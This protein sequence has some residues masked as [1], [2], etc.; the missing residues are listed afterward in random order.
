MEGSL[1]GGSGALRSI[2][3]CNESSLARSICNTVF[4]SVRVVLHSAT[5]VTIVISCITNFINSCITGSKLINLLFR[6]QKKKKK[7]KYKPK[8]KHV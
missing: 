4:Y 8:L 7:K 1:V 2:S 3:G 5:I 6:R